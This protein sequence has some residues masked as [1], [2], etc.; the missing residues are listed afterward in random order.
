M[1][2]E[3]VKFNNDNI[4]EIV[5]PEGVSGNYMITCYKREVGKRVSPYEYK[6]VIDEN[7]LGFEDNNARINNFNYLDWKAFYGEEKLR[8]LAADFSTEESVLPLIY[9]VKYYLGF[10]DDS[11]MERIR[12]TKWVFRR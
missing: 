3:F 9:F 10:P 2:S 8:K 4:W 12:S 5:H 1:G 11:K 6:Y 7:T